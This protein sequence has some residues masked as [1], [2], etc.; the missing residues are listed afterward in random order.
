MDEAIVDATAIAVRGYEILAVGSDA[1]IESYIGAETEVVEL[2]GR[3][4]MPGFIEGH[5]HFLPLGRSLQILDFAQVKSWEQVVNMVAGAAAQAEPG[6]WIFG[7]GWHQ[8][9]WQ[10]VPEG[11]VDGVP[12]NDGLNLAAPD[13]PV[14][15][16]HASGHAV[17]VNDAALAAAGVGDLSAN[18]PG[19]TIVRTPAGRATGLLRETAF[20]LLAP[21]LE[22][23]RLSRGEKVLQ[24]EKLEQVVLAGNE[25]LRNG[26]TSFH[27]AGTSF[28]DIDLLKFLEEEGHLPIRLYVMVQGPSLEEMDRMLPQYRMLASDNDFLVVRSIKRMIDGALGTHGAWLLAPY[29]DMPS[30]AGLTVDTVKHVQQAAAI[31]LKH[32]YQVNTHAIGDRGNRETLDIYQRAFIHQGVSGKDLRWRIEHVQHIDAADVPRFG[33]LGVI[34][35]MQGVHASSDGPWLATRLGEPR[36]GE[37]SYVWRDLLNAGAM[38]N[39]GTDVPVE[40]IDP[41]ASYYSSVTRMTYTGEV[42]HPE[43][44]MS[45]LEALKS[46]TINN[47]YAAFEENIKGSLTPGKLADIVVLSQNILMVEEANIPETTVDLTIIAGQVRYQRATD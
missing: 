12:R 2:R 25:A 39:N 22:A 5:G 31:A 20:G 26:V 32:G 44:A 15:L 21:A 37:I 42:F 11:A 38:I 4:A 34:A 23:Y 8:E 10:S 41:I 35:S 43:Q 46:Y 3:F 13:N 18:P 33:E 36:A 7:A 40:S 28:A 45:R 6:E 17:M 19:G 29:D 9:K 14:Y 30:T 24:A 27:D 16:E 47:A 1:E